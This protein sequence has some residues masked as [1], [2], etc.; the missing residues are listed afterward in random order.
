MSMIPTATQAAGQ[1]NNTGGASSFNQPWGGS[2]MSTGNAGKILDPV[3]ISGN[4][5][6]NKGAAE[7][8]LDPLGIDSGSYGLNLFGHRGQADPNGGVPTTLPNFGINPQFYDPNSFKPAST[9]GGY[10]NAMAQKMAGP[11]YNPTL[12]GGNT[13]SPMLPMMKKPGAPIK[14]GGVGSAQP[15]IQAL[16]AKFG[17]LR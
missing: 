5:G 3:G 8:F 1:N 10:W 2:G 17:G 14:G 12:M 9:G 15:N 6:M 4:G 7:S 13:P 16:L 11:T